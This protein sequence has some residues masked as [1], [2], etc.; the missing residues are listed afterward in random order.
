VNGAVTT[1]T[2]VGL[3]GT[4]ATTI[5][6]AVRAD[7]EQSPGSTGC[8]IH[9]SLSGD[10]IVA[11]WQWTTREQASD[12]V[13]RARVR[14]PGAPPA[15]AGDTQ[16]LTLRSL[17]AGPGHA[18]GEFSLRL[19]STAERP[20]LI[21][22]FDPKLRGREQLLRYLE[23]ASARFKSEVEGW[24]G[25]ALYCD[26]EG[27]RAVEYLQF[28]GMQGLSRS[29]ASPLIGAHQEELRKFGAVGANVYRVI[30]VCRR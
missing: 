30:D 12:H 20:A 6:A 26:E 1:L 9:A 17:R 21:A 14:P 16:L 3:A 24:V 29:Q 11:L 15:A 18:G 7:W 13:Q 23:Q 10:S 25:A 4:P 19:D 8:A 5:A 27:C 28:E 2:T 22:V